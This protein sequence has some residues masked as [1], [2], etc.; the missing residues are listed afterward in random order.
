MKSV[1]AFSVLMA[2]TA[3]A[4]A[5][6]REQLEQKAT[7][8]GLTNP[9]PKLKSQVPDLRGT[10]EAI[11]DST[12]EDL[13]KAVKQIA[14]DRQN[15]NQEL[16]TDEIKKIDEF[17]KDEPSEAVEALDLPPNKDESRSFQSMLFKYA[18][19]KPASDKLR[20]EA[21]ALRAALAEKDLGTSSGPSIADIVNE[22]K[23]SHFKTTQS[24]TSDKSKFKKEET[25]F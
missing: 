3:P 9:G 13:V 7:H 25:K 8:A 18:G 6:M 12:G 20:E 10:I 17:L 24:W 22:V 5:Q 2:L 16:K 15:P 19:Q 11:R 21:M 14:H 23:G 1:L 4:F